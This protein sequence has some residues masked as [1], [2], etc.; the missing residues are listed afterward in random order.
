MTVRN[1]RTLA[2]RNGLALALAVVLPGILL[3]PLASAESA[4]TSKGRSTAKKPQ[5]ETLQVT[6]S[7]GGESATS[8]LRAP[9]STGALGTA[10][11]LDTPF[12]VSTVTASEIQDKQITTARGLFASD[13]SITVPL[14][15]YSNVGG[16]IYIRGIST[17]ADGLIDGMNVD[18][19][20]QEFSPEIFER[21]DVLKG[22]TGFMYGFGAP[23]GI[24]NYVTKKPTD[25]PLLS[26]TAGFKS[27]GVFSQAIDAGGRGGQDDRYGLRLN[28]VN[29]RGNLPGYQSAITRQTAALS[30]DMRL[31]PGVTLYENLIYGRRNVR[32]PPASSFET[33][34][35]S[36][37]GGGLPSPINLRNFK[38]HFGDG[39]NNESLLNSQFGIKWDISDD[40]NLRTEYGYM[41]SKQTEVMG[42]PDNL[43]KNG[44]YE[45][46]VDDFSPVKRT[47]IAQSILQ[48]A[49]DTG[50]LRHNVT[51]GVN[52]HVFKR[53]HECY[54]KYRYYDFQGNGNIYD[55]A[56]YPYSRKPHPASSNFDKT[57]EQAA[58]ISDRLELSERWQL[59]AGIRHT[60]YK[61][62]TEGRDKDYDKSV[63]TPTLAL[64]FK[65]EAN[66]SLYTSYV[67]SLEEGSTV[68]NQYRNANEMLPPQKSKQYEVGV[69]TDQQRWSATAALF[70]IERASEYANADNV[71]VQDGEERYQGVE[72]A[73]K[74]IIT[75]NVDFSASTLWL[76]PTYRSVA[77][78]KDIKGNRVAGT[79]KFTS[80]A[81]LGWTPDALPDLRTALRWRHESK[82]SPDDTNNLHVPSHDIF[83]L[84]VNYE[85]DA[86]THPVS[87][88]FGITNLTNKKYWTAGHFN[89]IYVGDPRTVMASIS[90]QL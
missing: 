70:R 32:N 34:R 12:S 7:A 89:T 11:A 73:G 8:M 88:R 69:K 47:N 67:Q 56:T 28:L 44:D 81:E 61:Q 25:D 16:Q 62:E 38:T 83:D 55:K 17:A 90:V 15:S 39:R 46:Y 20:T 71:W 42:F 43:S 82:A 72:L 23:G 87:A 18:L 57:T 4:P 78:T 80:S 24:I 19:N 31:T 27:D 3:S 6:A 64:I 9:V 5:E 58:F 2:R 75:K 74:V 14:T 86:F 33:R 48:G 52:Y 63:N 29:E 37:S 68:G 21:V 65:P 59:L 79:S 49:V 77:P 84:F 53:C 40:W 50:F 35:L 30:L 60:N 26:A 76:D 45:M 1:R 22:A 66:T 54:G 36:T 10:S 41:K 85:T 51:A 13:A